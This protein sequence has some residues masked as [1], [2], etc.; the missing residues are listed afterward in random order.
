MTAIHCQRR[1]FLFVVWAV[2]LGLAV[3]GQAQT[4][5]P[6]TRPAISLAEVAP[7]VPA[8]EVIQSHITRLEQAKNLEESI[9]AQ[10]LEA[11]KQALVQLKVAK[12]W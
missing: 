7:S 1:T 12:N 9:R 11:Y 4:T 8:A 2:L 3:T 6:A 10:A 5:K